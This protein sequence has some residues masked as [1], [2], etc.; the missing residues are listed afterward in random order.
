AY[1]IAM[2][3]APNWLKMA[4]IPHTGQLITKAYMFTIFFALHLIYYK[5]WKIQRGIVLLLTLNILF[6]LFDLYD[7][8]NL[9]EAYLTAMPFK[10]ASALRPIWT[11]FIPIAWILGLHSRQV[12]Q[13]CSQIPEQQQA[14]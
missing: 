12:K 11:I 10:E 7:Q 8:R 3:Y 5:D 2:V 9:P 14:S 4:L 13:Y 1:D 6:G